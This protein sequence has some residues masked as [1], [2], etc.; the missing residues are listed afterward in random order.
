MILM[1][2][3]IILKKHV[4]IC[5]IIKMIK[6]TVMIDEL[7]I[8]HLRKLFCVVE[9]SFWDYH[10]HFR[11]HFHFCGKKVTFLDF[12]DPGWDWEVQKQT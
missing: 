1:M 4:E 6:I 11:L 10:F 8:D 9:K 5:V 2:I 7:I 3:I 12:L